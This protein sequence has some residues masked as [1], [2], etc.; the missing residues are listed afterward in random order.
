MKKIVLLL[1]FSIEFGFLNADYISKTSGKIIWDCEIKEFKDK[2]LFFRK[3]DKLYKI[4]IEFVE[5]FKIEANKEIGLVSNNEGIKVFKSW[6][7]D[8]EQLRKALYDLEGRDLFDKS[9]YTDLQK[10]DI[11]NTKY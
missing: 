4:G 7:Y 1:L 10:E 9:K 11:W 6:D 5:S 3:D 8:S 2:N